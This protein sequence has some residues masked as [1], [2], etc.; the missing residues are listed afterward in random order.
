MQSAYHQPKYNFC[1]DLWIIVSYFNPLNY[2]TR[3]F[4]YETFINAIDRSGLKHL[5]VE[6]SFEGQGFSLPDR[7]N[8]IKVR[9]RSVLWQKERLLNLAISWLPRSCKYVAWLDCDLLFTNPRWA[10]D[11]VRLLQEYPVVQLFERCI[12][13][14]QGDLWY[15]GEGN[16]T[17]S[18]ASITSQDPTTLHSGR[19]DDHGHT[20]YGW[21]ARREI[22]DH[23]G[24][25]EYAI[26]GSADHY[27]AHAIFGDFDGICLRRMMYDNQKLLHHFRDWAVKFYAEAGN[28]VAAVPGDVL[29]LWH[30]EMQN[31]QYLLRHRELAEHNFNPFTD[32]RSLP[33]RPLEWNTDN[34]PLKDWFRGYFASRCE[35]GDNRNTSEEKAA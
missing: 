34:Q 28:R 31:R 33:G 1:P 12:R 32:I 5:T 23:V 13:L 35:D 25:Y 9:S 8:V 18:F 22:L 11:T 26:A 24:L 2:Q 3:R 19:F 29:H 15:R 7:S 16:I 17:Q 20:G 10:V 14:P 30:G 21:A 27:I 6:C 4:N